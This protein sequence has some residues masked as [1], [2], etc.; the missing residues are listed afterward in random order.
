MTRCSVFSIETERAGQLAGNANVRLGLD[1]TVYDLSFH[2]IVIYSL[3]GAEFESVDD[4]TN[5][6]EAI[7]EAGLAADTEEVWLPNA[8]LESAKSPLEAGD[9]FRISE[10]LFRTAIRISEGSSDSERW[11]DYSAGCR[12]SELETR[13]FRSWHEQEVG[14]AVSQYPKDPTL[15][16]TWEDDR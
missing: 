6:F 8:V 14:A 9:V 16:L 10:A 15:V 4:L 7:D 11:T 3:N 12:F 5:L 1:A 2:G 13:V